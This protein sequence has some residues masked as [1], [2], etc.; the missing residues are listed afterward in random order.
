MKMIDNKNLSR[1]EKAVYSLRDIYESYG[2]SQ[3]KMSKFEEYDL[4][5]RNKSFL[6][7]DNIITFTDHDGKLICKCFGVTDL[8]I[9]AIAREHKLTRAEELTNY[10]KAGGACGACLGEIQHILDDMWKLEKAKI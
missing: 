8:K 9:I 7:S 1:A 6:V 2:Y 10:C 3:Y 5:V 4:Y